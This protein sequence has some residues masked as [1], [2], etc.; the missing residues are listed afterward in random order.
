VVH[1]DDG[2]IT[3]N[4]TRYDL[5]SMN[6]KGFVKQIAD[7]AKKYYNAEII[8]KSTT[9]SAKKSDSGTRAT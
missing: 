7:V 1:L 3:V 5:G 8:E 4:D 6:L 2:T 9:E